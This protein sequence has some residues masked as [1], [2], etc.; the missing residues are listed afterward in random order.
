[1]NLGEY[2]IYSDKM[3]LCQELLF[4]IVELLL[5]RI[6]IDLNW[7]QFPCWIVQSNKQ[8]PTNKAFCLNIS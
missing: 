3:K 2:V 8:I 6:K 1:M 4:S 5:E 7:F